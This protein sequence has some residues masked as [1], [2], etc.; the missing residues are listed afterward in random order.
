MNKPTSALKDMLQL[1]KISEEAD[2]MEIVLTNYSQSGTG[3]ERNRHSDNVRVKVTIT[4]S[5][6]KIKQK[7]GLRE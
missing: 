1:A 7:L 3:N 5:L 2:N 6:H 4:G